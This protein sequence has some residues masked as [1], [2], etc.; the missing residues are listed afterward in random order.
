M[1]PIPL[2]HR[3]LVWPSAGLIL[4]ILVTW[5][6]SA[7]QP[8]WSKSM[9][10][11]HI[12]IANGSVTLRHIQGVNSTVHVFGSESASFGL[13]LPFLSRHQS[14]NGK[15]QRTTVYMPL[16]LP[17]IFALF[18]PVLFWWKSNR[19]PIPSGHC[20]KCGYNLTGNK[21]GICSECGAAL[22]VELPGPSPTPTTRPI[23]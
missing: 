8:L 14:A 17:L 18:P 20:L 4:L 5:I 10:N 16:W 1:S 6:A 23:A 12:N 21:S 9:E 15:I 3:L 2:T 11:C 13:A 22:R 19:K 7:K